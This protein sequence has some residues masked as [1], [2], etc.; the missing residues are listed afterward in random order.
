MIDRIVTVDK[1]STDDQVWNVEHTVD[2]AVEH[3]QHVA[4]IAVN[5]ARRALLKWD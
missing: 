1:V 2:V 3:L 5:T 4:L